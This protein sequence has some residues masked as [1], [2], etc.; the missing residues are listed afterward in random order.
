MGQCTCGAVRWTGSESSA[1]GNPRRHRKA[2]ALPPALALLLLWGLGT[3]LSLFTECI[4]LLQS[5]M[6]RIRQR[7][8]KVGRAGGA[9][10]S[11]RA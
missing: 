9:A 7:F 2:M 1:G 8:I 4:L 3:S 5:E 11:R 10:R 6:K